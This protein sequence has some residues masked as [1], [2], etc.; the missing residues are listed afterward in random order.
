MPI[1]SKLSYSDIILKV[2]ADEPNRK[3]ATWE[4][5]MKQTRYGWIGSS[6]E[7]RARNLAEKGKINRDSSGQYAVFWHKAKE[8]KQLTLI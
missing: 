7:V 6:G 5:M 8:L 1:T 2:L 4:L 3:F